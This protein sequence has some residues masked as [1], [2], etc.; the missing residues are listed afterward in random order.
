MI[1]GDKIALRAWTEC[2]VEVL[3]DIRNDVQLQQLLMAR[4]KPNSRARTINWLTEKS[5]A[6]DTVFFVIA[7]MV[8]NK[9]VGY[10]QVVDIDFLDGT[11]YLGICLD[12]K[13]QGKG[14]GHEVLRLLETYMKNSFGMRKISLNVLSDNESAVA[15]YRKADY[16]EVG[17]MRDHFYLN[18]E[19]R[20]VLIMEKRLGR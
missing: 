20:D 19:F 4:A 13:A 17:R 12:W 15:F 7:E 6:Q 18:G 16:D 2:D 1:S 9:A 11:G 10:V 8:S 5:G 14:Y 3:V